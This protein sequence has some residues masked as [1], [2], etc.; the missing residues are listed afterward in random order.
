MH[1]KELPGLQCASQSA[2]GFRACVSNKAKANHREP[3]SRLGEF[4]RTHGREGLTS[5]KRL[6]NS[7]EWALLLELTLPLEEL[8]PFFFL[9]LEVEL[10]SDK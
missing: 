10:P 3:R 9:L 2:D 8:E 6:R 5:A 7:R 4:V 1:R